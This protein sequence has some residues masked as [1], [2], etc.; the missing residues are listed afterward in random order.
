MNYHAKSVIKLLKL[1][2]KTLF[3]F[4]LNSKKTSSVNSGICL[5]VA[6]DAV[7]GEH[8]TCQDEKKII[9]ELC[10]TYTPKMA[11]T[12]YIA[13]LHLVGRSVLHA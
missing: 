6:E 7:D 10:E 12:V 5:H 13:F 8:V 3:I 11:H 2:S 1:L 9:E 4:S